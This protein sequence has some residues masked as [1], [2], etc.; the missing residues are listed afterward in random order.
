MS[1]R[2]FLLFSLVFALLPG[3][4][5]AW[6]YPYDGNFKQ[7]TA[8][9]DPWCFVDNEHWYI[10]NPDK[11]QHFMGCY[12]AHQLL[13]RRTDKY[14]SGGIVMTLGLAKEIMDAYR[15]GYSVRDGL[16][17][18]LGIGASLLNNGSYTL[19]CTYTD[20]SVLLRLYFKTPL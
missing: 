9:R 16:A 7:L 1:A 4:V 5:Q 20:E 14:L 11:W 10:R 8:D 19:L 6:G 18:A 2:T 13:A 15:E 12:V 3:V 17:D